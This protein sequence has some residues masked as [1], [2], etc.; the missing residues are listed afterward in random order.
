[1]KGILPILLYFSIGNCSPNY[2]NKNFSLVVIAPHK[3]ASM[4]LYYYF[5]N[6]SSVIRAK[7]FST[8]IARQPEDRLM[9]TFLL[10]SHPKIFV[11]LRSLNDATLRSKMIK[12]HK[13]NFIFNYREPLDIA[14][15]AYHSFGFSHKPPPKNSP[16]YASFIEQQEI[17]Q[18]MTTEEYVTLTK[19]HQIDFYK[20]LTEFM[21]KL[22]CRMKVLSYEKLI[23]NQTSWN[24]DVAKFLSLPHALSKRFVK[25]LYVGAI[26]RLVSH[27]HDPF[28][29][30]RLN[31]LSLEFIKN[32]KHEMSNFT[33][34]IESHNS[35]CHG[36]HN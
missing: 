24:Q 23:K 5:Q 22:K 14:I 19:Q 30:A 32:Y 25:L 1:M 35:K 2:K 12:A 10:E 9:R 3:S 36:L 20:N 13:N 28:P 33:K 6:M 29:G 17:I 16:T 4:L 21:G 7:I 15:S 31:E 18:K 34:V 26:D 27:V 8:N 11:P